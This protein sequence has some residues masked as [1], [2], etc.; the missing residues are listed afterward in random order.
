MN[1]T[2]SV[3]TSLKNKVFQVNSQGWIKLVDW[4]GSDESIEQAARQSYGQGTRAVN[5]TR[6][7]LRYLMR[8]KHSSPFE[9]AE[10]VFQVY[11][12]MDIWRQWVRHRT[13]SVNEYS[14]RYSIAIDETYKTETWRKQSKTNKQGSCEPILD[15]ENLL[16]AIETGV[17]ENSTL[18][19]KDL[20]ALGVA[21]EQARK[22]LTLDTFTLATWKIDLNNLFKFLKLR[23]DNHAQ[24]EIRD[25]AKTISSVIKQLFPL[26]YEAFED[27]ELNSVTFSASECAWLGS[28][29]EK[30]D[31]YKMSKPDNMSGREFNELIEKIFKLKERNFNVNIDSAKQS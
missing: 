17:H 29:L 19:Y 21:R 9:M 28:V 18:S 15:P 1:T 6:N 20:I 11:V 4:M 25:Y 7:L 22:I 30:I 24:K 14:T 12:P 2:Q 5:D 3:D 26:A 27:Y 16:S 8:H 10:V 31:T 23:L 13:A